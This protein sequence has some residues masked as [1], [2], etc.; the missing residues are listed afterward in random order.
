M[1][2]VNVVVNFDLPYVYGT[3]DPDFEK[4]LHRVGRSGRFRRPGVAFNFM[5]VN[6]FKARWTLLVRMTEMCIRESMSNPCSVLQSILIVISQ[7]WTC[8]AVK[9][10]RGFW[11]M[12]VCILVDDPCSVQDITIFV[13]SFSHQRQSIVSEINVV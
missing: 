10:L 12:E 6:R 1:S 13:S 11:R 7:W 4:Y 8:T 3:N 9:S 5:D 2:Q